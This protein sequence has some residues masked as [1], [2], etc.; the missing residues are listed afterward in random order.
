MENI[1]VP[2]KI[3]TMVIRIIPMMLII[4]PTKAISAILIREQPKIIA[5]GGVATGII[6]A[7]DAEIVAGIINKSGFTF[8]VLATDATTGRIISEVAV[9]DVNSVIK[10]MPPQMNGIIINGETPARAANLFPIKRERPVDW[11]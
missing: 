5:L 2:R 9:L 6:N 8:I 3:K 4:S 11:K 1:Q 10:V 7:H